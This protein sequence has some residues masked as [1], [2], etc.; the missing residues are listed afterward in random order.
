MACDD[1]TVV[2]MKQPK[3]RREQVASRIGGWPAQRPSTR[4]ISR[5]RGKIAGTR[6]RSQ[7]LPTCLPV[8]VLPRCVDEKGWCGAVGGSLRVMEKRVGT[9]NGHESG[10][11]DKQKT[12]EERAETES[13]EKQIRSSQHGVKSCVGEGRGRR[14][15]GRAGG[16]RTEPTAKRSKHDGNE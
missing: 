5:R 15:E 9:T 1:E 4:S 13:G 16:R 12:K 10:C 8:V 3:G 6:F 14:S 7:H 11:N 2:E